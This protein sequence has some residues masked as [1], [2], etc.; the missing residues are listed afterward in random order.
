MKAFLIDSLR[1][2][3]GFSHNFVDRSVETLLA[4]V[5]GL[6]LWLFSTA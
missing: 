5:H 1:E 4:C 3:F 6:V 2:A